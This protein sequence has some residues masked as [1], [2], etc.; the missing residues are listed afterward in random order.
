MLAQSPI[1]GDARVLREAVCL[2]D[3]GH[4]VTLVGRAVPADASLPDGV[5]VRDAGRSAGLGSATGPSGGAASTVLP[6]SGRRAARWALLPEHRDR[7]EAD[8]RASAA[9]LVANLESDVVHA[10]DRNTLELGGRVS[11]ERSV[12]LVYDAHELW[13]HRGLPGRPTPLATRRA[14]AVETRWGRHASLVLTVSDGIADVLRSRGLDPVVVV[15]NTF[16]TCDRQPGGA[17][18]VSPSLVYAGRIGAGRDVEALVATAHGDMQVLLVGPTDP[19]YAARL[20]PPPGVEIRPAMPV[21][22]IDPLYRARGIAAVTLT[23]SCLNHRL[24]LPNKLFHA[25]R[26][27]V[28][29]VAADLPE[30]RR[31]VRRHD[32]GELYRSGDAESLAT[33]AAQVR[34][35]Y[36]T[37]LA[38]VAAARPE[39]SWEHDA[40]VLLD[41]YA[42]LRR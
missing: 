12:P 19:H 33:A 13:S 2:R 21:D 23:D 27:G 39:L 31:V 22:D 36:D 37:L 15:R 11:T 34:D 16:P 38:S 9:R 10:H 7:V 3:A 40:A 18:P 6:A 5:Q 35:R 29:V 20:R 4:E 1:A 28:P 25:V 42:T 30:L 32:L 26:A 41:G 17:R 14:T 24:S 8:W